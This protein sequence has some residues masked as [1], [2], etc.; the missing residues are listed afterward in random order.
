MGEEVDSRDKEM[1]GC[2]KEII[3]NMD[4]SKYI[5]NIKYADVCGNV[6]NLNL[7]LT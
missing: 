5:R 3:Y 4:I 6:C 7:I 2:K 1:S